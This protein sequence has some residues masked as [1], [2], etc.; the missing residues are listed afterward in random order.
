MDVSD[1]KREEPAGQH[2]IAA[3]PGPIR[4]YP[5]AQTGEADR[6]DIS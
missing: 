1:A 4:D 6:W 5:V 2:P 3:D